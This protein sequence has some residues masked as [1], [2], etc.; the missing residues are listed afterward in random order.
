MQNA[1]NVPVNTNISV[2]FNM[3]MDETTINDSTFVV[4]A[5]C[6]GLHQ[7]TISYNSQTRTATFD[8]AEDFDVGEVVTIVL[9]SGIKS[10]QGFRLDS[11]VW[12]FTVKVADGTGSGFSAQ[13]VYPVGDGPR[14]IYAALSQF[15]PCL[16]RYVQDAAY[17][18]KHQYLLKAS[19]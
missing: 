8:P 13:S 17:I 10:I 9:T 19:L 4:N 5:R 11:R 18:Q 1:L 6:T 16:V 14:A 7:G 2:N 15:C 12:S 3:D